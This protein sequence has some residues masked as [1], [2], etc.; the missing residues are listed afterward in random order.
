VCVVGLLSFLLSDQHQCE[1]EIENWNLEIVG[2]GRRRRR[3]PYQT[4]PPILSRGPGGDTGL[5]KYQPPPR[6][7]LLT[8]VKRNCFSSSRFFQFLEFSA[9]LKKAPTMKE[10]K[11]DARLVLGEGQDHTKSISKGCLIEKTTQILLKCSL[12]SVLHPTVVLL[13]DSLG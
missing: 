1:C 4:P 6:V 3:S 9:V 10:A 7:T 2:S 12:F 8:E 13:T 5:G 11:K